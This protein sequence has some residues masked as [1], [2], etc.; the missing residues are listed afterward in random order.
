MTFILQHL[1]AINSNHILPQK[2]NYTCIL[3][4]RTMECRAKAM[5]TKKIMLMVWMITA[6]L[7]NSMIANAMEDRHLGTRCLFNDAPCLTSDSQWGY[8]VPA[9][10]TGG[11]CWCVRTRCVRYPGWRSRFCYCAEVRCQRRSTTTDPYWP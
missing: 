4:F 1:L 10:Q 6:M 2:H 3:Y 8:L 11:N 5:F 9:R 7:T